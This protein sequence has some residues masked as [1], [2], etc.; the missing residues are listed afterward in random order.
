MA[1]ISKSSPPSRTRSGPRMHTPEA[2]IGILRQ[3]FEL[4][5]RAI[6]LPDQRTRASSTLTTASLISRAQALHAGRAD[7]PHDDFAESI[8]HQARQSV[9]FAEYQPVIRARRASFSRAAP[10]PR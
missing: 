6:V 9:G 5:H 2:D 3:R 7:L 4:A 10:T 1:S 8:Q